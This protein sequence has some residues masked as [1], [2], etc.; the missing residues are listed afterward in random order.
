MFLLTL[1]ATSFILALTLAQGLIALKAYKENAFA[2]IVGI[3]SFVVAVSL[4]N[5]LILRNELGFLAGGTAA[6]IVMA[7]LLIPRMRAGGASLQDLVQVV[8]HEPLEI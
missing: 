2:W 7:G 3:V 4:G 8:E 1:A 6:A 5:D